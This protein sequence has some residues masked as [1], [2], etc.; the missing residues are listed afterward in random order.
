[1]LASRRKNLNH[2]HHVSATE[3]VLIPIK[4]IRKCDKTLRM[5]FGGNLEENDKEM[6]ADLRRKIPPGR[7]DSKP[8]WRRLL[9][10]SKR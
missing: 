5:T 10:Q 2:N 1:M 6:A 7:R 3:R 9:L 4:F 8:K